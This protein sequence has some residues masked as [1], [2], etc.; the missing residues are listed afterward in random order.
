MRVRMGEEGEG[1]SKKGRT[2]D[3]GLGARFNVRDALVEGTHH[4]LPGGLQARASREKERKEKRNKKKQ[5]KKKKKQKRKE[6][7]HS[8]SK[9]H[10]VSDDCACLVLAIEDIE[11]QIF[12]L[13][14]QR[15][16][17]VEN[18]IDARRVARHG[19][20]LGTE[21][22]IELEEGKR[23]KR[24]KKREKEEGPSAN[25]TDTN[26]ILLSR[27][28]SSVCATSNRFSQILLL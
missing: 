20:E 28:W 17:K 3:E 21:E 2:I 16:H 5:K 7:Q 1:K 9:T 25:K 22:A 14:R 23:K 13:Q 6:E 12:Q 8:A 11:G 26:I 18:R 10:R 15:A 27:T 4:R 24:N 19:L